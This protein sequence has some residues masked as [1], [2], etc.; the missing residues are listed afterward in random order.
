MCVGIKNVSS[1]ILGISSFYISIH[2]H[3]FFILFSIAK[4]LKNYII[5]SCVFAHKHF[6]SEHKFSWGNAHIFRDNAKVYIAIYFPI[7]I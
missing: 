7:I 6:A 3:S 4:T 5:S 1:L 2:L